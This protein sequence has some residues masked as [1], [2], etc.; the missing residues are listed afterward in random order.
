MNAPPRKPGGTWRRAIRYALQ[1]TRNLGDAWSWEQVTLP[2]LPTAV[3][4]IVTS[5]FGSIRQSAWATAVVLLLTLFLLALNAARRLAAEVGAYE[6]APR[7]FLRFVDTEVAGASVFGI[8]QSGERGTL[9]TREGK[10]VCYQFARVGI[11]N[12]P[13]PDSKGVKAE[14]VVAHITFERNGSAVIHEILGRWSETE[15]RA[16]TGR[17]GIFLEN[18]QLDIDPNGLR[19]PLDIAMKA[20]D[21]SSCYAYN[22]DNSNLADL[23]LPIHELVGEEFT[24]HVRLRG[25]STDEISASFLLENGGAG[26]GISFRRLEEKEISA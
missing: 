13:P 20:P 16:E 25:A 26:S 8:T 19:H 10:P 24:V 6:I 23:R 15:Q 4:A 17:I 22:E 11:K 3:L 14:K 18:A 5:V 12:D 1:P 2:L 21:D 7:P 9:V